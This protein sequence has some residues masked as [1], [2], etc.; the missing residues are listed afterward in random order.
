MTISEVA[1]KIG[2]IVEE[3]N[4]AYGS[5]FTKVAEALKVLY[6]EGIK[7]EQYQDVAVLIRIFDKMM[8]ISNGHHDDSWSDIAGYGIL[9]EHRR[10]SGN[11]RKEIPTQLCH[12]CKKSFK[13]DDDI[14][15]DRHYDDRWYHRKCFEPVCCYCQKIILD[16]NWYYIADKRYAHGLCHDKAIIENR[17]FD[18]E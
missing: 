18:E 8:R 1:T 12:H 6:P 3:K 17:D 14:I 16:R 7:T 11:T 5:A 13:E 10:N 4:K 15:R 2:S 9:M